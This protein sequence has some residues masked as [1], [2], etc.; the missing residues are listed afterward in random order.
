M[1]DNKKC[2]PLPTN[3]RPDDLACGQ[4]SACFSV[5]RAVDERKSRM[6]CERDAIIE[7]LRMDCARMAALAIDNARD[8]AKLQERIDHLEGERDLVHVDIYEHLLHKAPHMGVALHIDGTAQELVGDVIAWVDNAAAALA[9]RDVVSLQTFRRVEEERNAATKRAEEQEAKLKRAIDII[10]SE[11]LDRDFGEPPTTRNLEV[12][13]LLTECGHQPERC[14]RGAIV[15]YSGTALVE[16][17]RADDIHDL[18]DKM[19]VL[20]EGVAEGWS[21]SL[22]NKGAAAFFA[23]EEAQQVYTRC[24]A[25]YG[26]PEVPPSCESGEGE[27]MKDG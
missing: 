13:A 18:M 12:R 27:A 11:E 8:T 1:T 25:R 21:D 15:G 23:V 7:K 3:C 5:L 9:G 20:M 6:L 26:T 10:V 22:D 4:C 17:E 16:A 19:A 14:S 24:A 2:P